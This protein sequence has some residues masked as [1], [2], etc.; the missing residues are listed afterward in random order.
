METKRQSKVAKLIQK[1]LAEILRSSTFG[2]SKNDS[3]D[4]MT[5]RLPTPTLSHPTDHGG[6]SR[7][8]PI[9]PP[10]THPILQTSGTGGVLKLVVWG[11]ARCVYQL[12]SIKALH[13]PPTP[14]WDTDNTGNYTNTLKP[15]T[16]KTLMFIAGA[17]ELIPKP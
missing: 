17:A 6:R 14:C 2:L 4:Y 12:Q 9:S 1:E 10:P 13:P 16:N 7:S 3:N 8:F 5:H 15:T 11:G